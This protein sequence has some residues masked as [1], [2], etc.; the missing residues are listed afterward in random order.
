MS[1]GKVSAGPQ[2]RRLA[3]KIRTL[4]TLAGRGWVIDLSEEGL[5]TLRL[6]H[7][8]RAIGT[9]ESY[10]TTVWYRAPK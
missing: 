5:L 6:P 8:A 10:Y 3:W 1:P 2:A 9:V 4:A 7:H